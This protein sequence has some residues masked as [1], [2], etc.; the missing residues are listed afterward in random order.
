LVYRKGVIYIY[1]DIYDFAYQCWGVIARKLLLLRGVAGEV[2][3]LADV[4]LQAVN[5]DLEQR[6]LVIVQVGQRTQGLLGT[7]G[8]DVC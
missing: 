2:N 6:L 7:V 5:S 4:S 1:I 3:T 8:L